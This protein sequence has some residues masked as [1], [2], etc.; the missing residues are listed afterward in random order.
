V[1]LHHA[2]SANAERGDGALQMAQA[3]GSAAGGTDD[4]TQ[5]QQHETPLGRCRALP[6]AGRDRFK[7]IFFS[8]ASSAP[9]RCRRRSGPRQPSSLPLAPLGFGTCTMSTIVVS[10]TIS[11]FHTAN[12][13]NK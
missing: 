12:P 1:E 8:R 5:N 13:D 3:A 7:P 4:G 10:A 6:L 9:S 11:A 2:D